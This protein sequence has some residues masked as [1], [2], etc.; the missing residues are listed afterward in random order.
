MAKAGGCRSDQTRSVMTISGTRVRCAQL[1]KGCLSAAMSE[2]L[3]VRQGDFP[4]HQE[5]IAWPN[6]NLP[7]R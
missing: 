2:L 4:G 3:A 6:A 1:P 7:A 5:I